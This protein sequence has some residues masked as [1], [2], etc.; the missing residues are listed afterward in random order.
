VSAP[1]VDLPSPTTVDHFLDGR[2]V[3]EQPAKGRHRAGLDAILLAATVAENATG[4]LVDLGAGVGTAGLAAA[5]R[6]PGLTVRL[7]ERD[8]P[9][10]RLAAANIDRNGLAGRATAIAVDLLGPASAREAALGRESADHVI[11]NPPFFA[12][13]AVRPS[14]SARAGAHVLGDGGLDAWVRV[15]AATLAPHGRLSLIFEGTG[16]GEILTALAGRFGAAAIRPVH[17]RAEAPAHRLIV[18]AIRG[19]RARP[20]VLPGLVLHPAGSNA[21]LPPADAVLRGHAGLG[22]GR[23]DIG[24]RT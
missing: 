8:P 15:A 3:V 9:A 4:V 24:V 12:P 10:L 11:C 21:Y 1:I 5:V 6:A 17:P 13:R 7:A 14:P 2:L 20:V 18:T 23:D 16:L 19:S 22:S